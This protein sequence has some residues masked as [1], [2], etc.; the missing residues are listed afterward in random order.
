VL[1]LVR[2]EKARQELRELGVT[3]V[4]VTSD[5]D[6]ERDLASRAAEL[7][8]TAV[9]DGIGGE[10]IGRIVPHLPANA[11]IYGYG[12]LGGNTPLGVTSLDVMLKNLTIKR[13]SN[14]ESA[15]V[16]D[17]GRLAAALTALAGIA[18]DPLFRTRMGQEFAYEEIDS[19]MQYKA[20]GGL[21]AILVA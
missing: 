21:K 14:F 19:A 20:A 3:S 17:D 11:T 18:A 15:T 10:L 1:H 13:F 2:T 9:F 6:F 12:F 4:L 5:P 7:G 8:A 16:R